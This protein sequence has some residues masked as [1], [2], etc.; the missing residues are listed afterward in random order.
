MFCIWFVIAAFSDLTMLFGHNEGYLTCKKTFNNFWDYQIT[1]V[2]NG[3]GK[4]CMCL[5]V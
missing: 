3:R 1:G 2:K 5:I 4:G